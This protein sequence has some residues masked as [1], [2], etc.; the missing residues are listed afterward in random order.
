MVAN[1][2]EV[3]EDFQHKFHLEWSTCTTPLNSAQECSTS[4]LLCLCCAIEDDELI[5]DS[6]QGMA[7][8]DAISYPLTHYIN[9]VDAAYTK[10]ST[11]TQYQYY[12]QLKYQKEW[13]EGLVYL[14]VQGIPASIS[15]FQ[16]K[17]ESVEG[18]ELKPELAQKVVSES[19]SIGQ[20]MMMQQYHLGEDAFDSPIIG[21]HKDRKTNKWYFKASDTQA[22]TIA[23]L[24]PEIQEMLTNLLGDEFKNAFHS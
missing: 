7:K 15:L 14:T 2:V 23:L 12:M 6:I 17:P 1:G 21:V 9:F 19:M 10:D 22:D 20:I 4:G 13:L 3:N 8:A 24:A 18:V 16:Y 11:A 5:E